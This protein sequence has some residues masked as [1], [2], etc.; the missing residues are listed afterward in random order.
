MHS[1]PV[2]FDRESCSSPTVDARE[3]PTSANVEEHSL[4]WRGS[5]STSSTGFCSL[6]RNSNNTRQEVRGTWYGIYLKRS[7]KHQKR[8]MSA[9][10]IY[11]SWCCRWLDWSMSWNREESERWEHRWWRW[12]WFPCAPERRLLVESIGCSPSMMDRRLVLGEIPCRHKC[13]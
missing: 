4:I 9:E 12:P 7:T 11:R 5:F 1:S 2:V 8:K 3:P 10:R 6:I 13:I